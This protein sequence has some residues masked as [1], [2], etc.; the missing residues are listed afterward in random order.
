MFPGT[1][2]LSPR[3]A[4]V[5]LITASWATHAVRAMAALGLADH[6]AGGP[7]TA[8]ELTEATGTDAPTF[9]R[10][11]R[12]LAALGLVTHDADD[13]SAGYAPADCARR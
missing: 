1:E 8:R 2:G 9:A 12:T 3:A 10:F 5:Q 13:R 7:R 4:L 6:L 11:L